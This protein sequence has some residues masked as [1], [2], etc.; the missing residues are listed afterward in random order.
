MSFRV[1]FPEGTGEGDRATVCTGTASGTANWAPTVGVAAVA[2]AAA[3]NRGRRDRLSRR[4]LAERGEAPRQSKTSRSAVTE[5]LVTS[6]DPSAGPEGT[7]QVGIDFKNWLQSAE[8]E[9]EVDGLRVEGHIPAW[10]R[11]NLAPALGDILPSVNTARLP[12]CFNMLSETT[13]EE[14]DLEESVPS[15]LNRC[16]EERDVFAEEEALLQPR[17][18]RGVPGAGQILPS[19]RERGLEDFAVAFG[20]GGVRSGAFCSGALWALAEAGRLRHVT[21]LSS[22]SGGS[23]AASGFASFLVARQPTGIQVQGKETEPEATDRWYRDPR[24]KGGGLASLEPPKSEERRAQSEAAR[25][26]QPSVI[27]VA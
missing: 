2:A 11:G 4:A 7:Y 24:L 10:L 9:L 20:G 25:L 13:D 19:E 12:S 14:E 21:H 5:K 22:V 15:G 16:L 18:E 27:R 6:I 3:V 26:A 23:I 17:R 1:Y 8:E